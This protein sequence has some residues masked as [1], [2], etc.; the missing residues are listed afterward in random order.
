M[1]STLAGKGLPV[2]RLGAF[3]HTATTVLPQLVKKLI[4]SRPAWRP[5]IIDGRA[6]HLM[7]LLLRGEIDL[8]LGRLPSRDADAPDAQSL[9]QRVLYES[10]LSVVAARKH[11]L[12]GK[13][14][15][16]L[17]ELAHWPWI[18]PDK[19]S[20]TRVALVDAFLRCGIVPPV[21]MVESPSFFYSLSVVAQTDLLTCCAQSAALQSG[22]ATT[23]LPITVTLDPMPVALVWRKDSI[24][25]QRV[26]DLL[27][28]PLTAASTV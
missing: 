27:L 2:V 10:S 15:L 9:T 3:P 24:L 20:T 13:R 21:P 7:Q 22:Q 16:Q 25:A 28:R 19:Q 14:K 17:A 4:D 12:A 1:G 26:A 23:I 5:R 18:L 11:P 6:D 8:L